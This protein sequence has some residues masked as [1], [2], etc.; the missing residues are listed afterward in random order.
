M[1]TTTR[2]NGHTPL[3]SLYLVHPDRTQPR[4]HAVRCQACGTKTWNVGARC[5]QHYPTRT[6]VTTAEVDHL[7]LAGSN[8]PLDLWATVAAALADGLITPDTARDI[9][10]GAS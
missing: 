2:I 4:E 10:G 3:D 6:S 7:E 8:V 9:I 1:D 5:D